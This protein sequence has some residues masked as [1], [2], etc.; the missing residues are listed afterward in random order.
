M[1]LDYISRI[2]RLRKVL[3]D[4][5]SDLDFAVQYVESDP[6]ASLGKCRLCTE[7]LIREL[8]SRY[9][10]KEPTQTGDPLNEPMLHRIMG[11]PR[12]IRLRYARELANNA[13]HINPDPSTPADA[14]AALDALAEVLEWWRDLNPRSGPGRRPSRPMR[15][16]LDDAST[17]ESDALSQQAKVV[18]QTRPPR[19]TRSRLRIA[20]AGGALA[21]ALLGFWALRTGTQ[22]LLS[23]A[24]SSATQSP[25][26]PTLPEPAANEP[27]QPQTAQRT[28]SP[29]TPPNQPPR[30]LPA[31]PLPPA[32]S[33]GP[34]DATWSR[35]QSHVLVDLYSV[36]SDATGQVYASGADGVI[37][38]TRDGGRKWHSVPTGTRAK[39][40]ALAQKSDGRVFATGTQGTLLMPGHAEPD[41][42]VRFRPRPLPQAHFADLWAACG[43][44]G[45]DLFVGGDQGVLLQLSADGSVRQQP[46]H[47]GARLR[48]IAEVDARTLFAVGDG[49]TVLRGELRGVLATWQPIA[50]LDTGDLW[51]LL[52]WGKRLLIAGDYQRE[53][54][55]KHIKEGLV[56]SGAYPAG[57]QRSR[58]P[59]GTNPV[60]S[61]LGLPGDVVLAAA[62]V[63]T[64]PYLLLSPDG[65]ATW[66]K[67]SGDGLPTRL[68]V[69]KY[70]IGKSPLGDLFIVGPKGM[71][72]HRRLAPAGTSQG[73]PR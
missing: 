58:M 57:W 42:S 16:M 14:E 47:K 18:E 49:G 45:G 71:I 27:P 8:Y 21:L 66:Q 48:A 13:A 64:Q 40:F 2:E 51:G 73:S 4:Y 60:Y 6:I 38:V 26:L 11:K 5:D 30:A 44:S 17:S 55:G 46:E 28:P 70:A 59:I 10:G 7:R 3:P 52:P 41:G 53:L 37:V 34:E 62:Y 29:E 1:A 39:L 61:L 72:L 20:I 43:H 32:P 54:A 12:L 23:G 24:L 67:Q 25:A 22:S 19:A 15:P 33:A 56:L 50:V 31:E 69:G 65:G 68:P 35:Q 36:Q 63:G 9:V